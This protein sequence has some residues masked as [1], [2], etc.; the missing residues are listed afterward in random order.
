MPFPPPMNS[1]AATMLVAK[2]AIATGMPIIISVTPRPNRISATQY[3]SI[4]G[5]FGGGDGREEAL[6]TH[7][8]AQELH[9]H[10]GERER[11]EAHHHPAR[12]VERAR[13]RRRLPQTECQA[14][15]VHL[16]VEP[17]RGVEKERRLAHRLPD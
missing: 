14:R 13:L 3:H 15:A 16:V 9:R 1:I 6:A 17:R 5:L 2:K 4:S 8:E 11:D 12:H 7:D 10:H